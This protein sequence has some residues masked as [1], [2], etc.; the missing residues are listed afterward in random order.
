MARDGE[1]VEIEGVRLSSPDRV[2][3]PEQG[4]TKRGLAEY[5]V[6]V[7]DAVLPQLRGRPLTL[8]RCP[9]GQEKQCF[10][11]RRADEGFPASIRRVQV[12]TDEGEA[13]YVV[14]DT[15]PALLALVQLGTLE[16]HTWS[17]RRDRLDRPD[18]L[19]LDL[20][21]DP[22][23][24]F[25]AVAEAAAEV[26]ERLRALGLESWVKTSGGKGLHVVAPLVRRSDWEEVRAFTRTVAEGMERDDPDR[27]VAEAA[28]AERGG[29]I[30]VDYLRNAW[31]ASAVAAYSTRARPGAPVST[32]LSWVELAEGAEPGD[33][34]VETVPARLAATDP[35]DGYEVA[36]Q[37]LTR[38]VLRRAGVPST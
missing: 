17:A 10:V 26:R 16:L 3:F 25:R 32:P 6:A 29:R 19:I 13:T 35:W 15:L 24:P 27:F 2:L 11:Q 9:R 14:V 18:R 12:P 36:R 34:T 38:E 7:A 21:P 28:K 20:D 8:I 23:L 5:Y 33:F 37:G 30:F 4:I 22:A 1:A 31:S